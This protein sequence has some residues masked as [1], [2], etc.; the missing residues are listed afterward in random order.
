MNTRTIFLA[1]LFGLYCLLVALAMAA[2]KTA[3]VVTVVALV[4]DAPLLFV[5][6]IITVAIGLAMTLAHNVW[7]GG[8]LPVVV[9]LIGWTTLAKGLL[10]LFLPA[11]AAAALFMGA[12][13]YEQ[14]FYRYALF[15]LLLGAYL[16]LAARRS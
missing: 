11:G 16:V 4:H 3:T 14:Y 9:T 2:H 5:V 10:F 6:A 12:L 1:R 8:A 15:T 7:S 13:H